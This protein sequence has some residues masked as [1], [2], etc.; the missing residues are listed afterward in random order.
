MYKMY[1]SVIQRYYIDIPLP[2]HRVGKM[3]ATHNML[4]LRNVLFV[5]IQ[6]NTTSRIPYSP[7]VEN[8][9]K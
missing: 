3:R 1:S 7:V 8:R 9:N 2:I 4:L 6:T 5:Q